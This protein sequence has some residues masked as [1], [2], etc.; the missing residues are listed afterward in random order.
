[1]QCEYCKNPREP[2][3]VACPGCG[4]PYFSLSAAQLEALQPQQRFMFI[5]LSDAKYERG[6]ELS[7]VPAVYLHKEV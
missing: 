2:F 7:T 5:S 6:Q 4:A 1:M 3:K